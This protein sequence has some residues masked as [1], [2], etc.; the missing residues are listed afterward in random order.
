M[1]LNHK[2]VHSA[3]VRL[4]QMVDKLVNERAR[5]V[6]ARLRQGQGK[7]TG[8][9]SCEGFAQRYAQS[10]HGLD[11]SMETLTRLSGALGQALQGSARDLDASDER[12][13]QALQA[14]V[15]RCEEE[16]T[17]RQV[18]TPYDIDPQEMDNYEF[19]PPPVE[20]APVDAGAAEQGGAPTSGGFGAP[21]GTP[22]PQAAAPAPTA[23]TG[24]GATPQP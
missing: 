18:C 16:I 4:Q 17:A 11:Q 9:R 1:E 22:Q 3:V 21:S 2:D 19:T 15:E 7:W 23:G 8:N 24:F 20:A 5:L 12:T 6:D 13:A 10:L 14:I